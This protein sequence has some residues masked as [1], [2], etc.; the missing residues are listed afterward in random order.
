MPYLRPAFLTDAPPTPP[1]AEG[2]WSITGRDPSGTPL[3]SLSFDMSEFTDT[4]DERGGF[5][6][7]LPVTWTGELAGIALE[8]PGGAASLD[9]NTD[10]PVTILR[11]S[12]TG[13]IRGFLEGIPAQAQAAAAGFTAAE[14]Q[15]VDVLFSRG[16]P[17]TGQEQ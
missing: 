1:S 5:A 2:A 13:R 12:A 6:F 17:G 7:A 16:I 9:R 15:G 8:G 4:E 10:D 11:D 3:F 14:R